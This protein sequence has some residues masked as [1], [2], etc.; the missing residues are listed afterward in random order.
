MGHDWEID[1]EPGMILRFRDG[2]LRK[3]TD[4]DDGGDILYSEPITRDE[5]TTE[6]KKA[7]FVLELNFIAMPEAYAKPKSKKWRV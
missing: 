2:S 4:V 5:L 3:V 7:I 6:Q 1:L